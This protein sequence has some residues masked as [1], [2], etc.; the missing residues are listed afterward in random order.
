MA[1]CMAIIVAAAFFPVQAGSPAGKQALSLCDFG[2]K[3]GL[4]GVLGLIGGR[5][6]RLR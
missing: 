3:S 4:G 2:F 1:V 5:S 6:G